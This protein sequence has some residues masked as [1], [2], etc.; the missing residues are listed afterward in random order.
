MKIAIIFFTFVTFSGRKM[1]WWY[2]QDRGKS[3][4]QREYLD[5]K[6]FRDL[7][8]Y[9]AMRM[10]GPLVQLPC[11]DRFNEIV[12]FSK[13]LFTTL[14]ALHNFVRKNGGIYNNYVVI[15]TLFFKLIYSKQSDV[16]ETMSHCLS[17]YGKSG[18]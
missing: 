12:L 14:I 18:K 17:P 11:L 7:W 3:S 15:V 9:C 10:Y 8:Q 6:N 5:L 13:M 16:G 2:L 4:T 1:A